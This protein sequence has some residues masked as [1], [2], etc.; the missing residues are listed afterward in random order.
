MSFLLLCLLARFWLFL[1]WLVSVK[2]AKYL[3]QLIDIHSP[4]ESTIVIFKFFLT[5]LNEL[6]TCVSEQFTGRESR[7]VIFV[8]TL[9]AILMNV[10]H[11]TVSLFKGPGLT[12]LCRY[13]LNHQQITCTEYHTVPLS[14]YAFVNFTRYF[15]SFIISNYQKINGLKVNS[16][17]I[18]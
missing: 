11:S 12:I 14:L 18:I 13:H 16:K 8:F 6:F 10:S 5:L 2:E 7:K 4:E 15:G 9:L 1:H 17:Q 3:R